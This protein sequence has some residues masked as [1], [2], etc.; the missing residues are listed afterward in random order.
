MAKGR[1][2]A[3]S[4]LKAPPRSLYVR[5]NPNKGSLR[6]LQSHDSTNKGEWESSE[7]WN[8]SWADIGAM[9]EYS[10]YGNSSGGPGDPNASLSGSWVQDDIGW[11]YRN[12]DQTYPAS[13][14]QEIGG[15]WYYFNEYGYMVTGWVLSGG[16]WYYCGADGAMLTDTVTPDGYTVDGSGAWVQG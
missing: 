8:I 7:P 12:G 16:I 10:Y 2:A 15:K 9:P 14:W 13:R 5:K 1:K 6:Q 4:G 11:W 3:H